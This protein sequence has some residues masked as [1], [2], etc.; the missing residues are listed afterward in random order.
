MTE[1]QFEEFE[2]DFDMEPA[3][4]QVWMLGYDKNECITDFDVL[5]EEFDDP[6]PAVEF[7]RNFAETNKV[8]SFNLPDDVKYVEVLVETVVQYD[9]GS[10]DENVET[11]YMA[12]IRL[13]D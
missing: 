12:T 2:E 1:E 4:Y 3:T 10:M 7:A 8:R 5:L 9:D 13:E 6:D 11:I